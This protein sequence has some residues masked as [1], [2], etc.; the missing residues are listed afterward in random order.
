MAV[1]YVVATPIGNLDD[2]TVRARDTLLS[3]RYVACEDTRHSRI[4]LQHIGSSA[5]LLRCDANRS[6]Q[7][8]P[9]IINLLEQ[10]ESVAY[11]TDA[12]TPGISDPGQSLVSATR[13]SGYQVIPIP[14]VSAVTTL[15]SVSGVRGPGW[16]FAGFLPVK[17]G[18][19][20]TRLNALI[21]MKEPFLVYEGPHRIDRLLQEL[22]EVVPTAELCI[23]REMTKSHEQFI[24]GNAADLAAKSANGGM[25]LKGEFTILVSP[26]ENS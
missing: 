10:E 11:I 15:L 12:G 1:L 25:T 16:H 18:K 2:L 24:T 4:L 8:I 9:G 14:G 7:C 26:P 13:A 17:S 22:A 21:E 3:V 6:A 5:R 19:R 23:G 20:K